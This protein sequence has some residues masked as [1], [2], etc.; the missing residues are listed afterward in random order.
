[1][2]VFTKW[3][4]SLM[5][6]LFAVNYWTVNIFGDIVAVPIIILLVTAGKWLYV[7]IWGI[8]DDGAGNSDASS[9]RKWFTKRTV[10]VMILL[11]LFQFMQDS[12][13]GEPAIANSPAEYV[14][15]TTIGVILVTLAGKYVYLLIFRTSESAS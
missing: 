4:V 2:R 14:I 13:R 11:Y 1:M 12:A 9:D 5:V 10:S 6:A 3:T 15:G 8:S 7:R